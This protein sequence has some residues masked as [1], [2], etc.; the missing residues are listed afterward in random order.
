MPWRQTTSPSWGSPTARWETE[1][2][3]DE[4]LEA[5]KQRLSGVAA[6]YPRSRSPRSAHT[7]SRSHASLGTVLEVSPRIVK[8]LQRQIHGKLSLFVSL[9]SIFQVLL[10]KCIASRSLVVLIPV[11]RRGFHVGASKTMGNMAYTAAI[12]SEVDFENDT[13]AAVDHRTES[14]V[15]FARG[16]S[17][18]PVD[19]ALGAISS[20]VREQSIMF[21]FSRA[22]VHDDCPQVSDVPD[23]V[24]PL[25]PAMV[26]LTINV[27]ERGDEL[28]ISAAY[29]RGK[30]DANFME[31]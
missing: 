21:V 18:V 26:D 5:W 10:H 11:S 6:F 23:D 9:L 4:A 22:A 31:G 20:N 29:D 14:F 7:D 13:F 25:A 8:E 27:V 1:S 12:G 28:S 2:R 17:F 19:K 30:Y 24:L 3:R 15:A 16:N